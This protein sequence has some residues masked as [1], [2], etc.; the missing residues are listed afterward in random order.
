MNA[1]KVAFL[2][3]FFDYQ[4]EISH[5]T[6]SSKGLVSFPSVACTWEFRVSNIEHLLVVECC[7]MRLRRPTDLTVY[8]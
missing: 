1:E 4:P 2:F 8:V 7:I 5:E 3:Q 6:D